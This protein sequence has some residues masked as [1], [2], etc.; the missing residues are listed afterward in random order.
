[1]QNHKPPD[2]KKNPLSHQRGFGVDREGQQVQLTVH[3]C[4]PSPAHCQILAIKLTEYTKA[5]G[6]TARCW[7]NHGTGHRIIIKTTIIILH[8]PH[9]VVKMRGCKMSAHHN[10]VTPAQQNAL[11]AIIRRV[12]KAHY[13]QTKVDLAIPLETPIPRLSKGQAWRLINHYNTGR[14][15]R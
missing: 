1:M 7:A 6:P 9:P 12:G 3:N 13:R 10:P 2:N 11:I 15:A 8:P 4:S 5:K 14:G